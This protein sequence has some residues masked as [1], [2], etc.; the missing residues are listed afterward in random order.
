MPAYL[1][2][3]LVFIVIVILLYIVCLYP[4]RQRDIYPFDKVK[5]AHRGLHDDNTPENSIAAFR[6]AKDVGFGVE[7]DIQ[8]TADK[9]V[10]VFHDADLKRMCGIDKR[11]DALTYDELTQ[12]T[13]LESD[14]HIPLLSDVLEALDTTPVL[15]EIKS[16]GAVTDCSLC[17]AAYPL[18]LAYGGPLCV[19]SF[20]PFVIRW[21]RRHHPDIIR[22]ILS[23]KYDDTSGVTRVQQIL[24]TALLTNCIT[25]P[26][27]IAFKYADRREFSLRICRT[28]FHSATF[29]WTIRSQAAE[30]EAL[31]TFDTVIFE[32]YVPKKRF[33]DER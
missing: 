19:E 4:G 10:V 6:A 13:L 11:V 25:R 15:C 28:L 31:R 3:L 5:Y 26:D 2:A 27:F 29:A 33:S 30:N 32:K 8:F 22:G 24:L 1:I 21:F 23:M 20:N 9:Q 7:L 16:H 17:E 14:Q 12:Y 18:L